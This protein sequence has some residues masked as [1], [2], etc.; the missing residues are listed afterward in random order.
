MLIISTHVKI[1][2]TLLHKLKWVFT[3]HGGV[4]SDYES[5]VKTAVASAL[6]HTSLV[7]L[8]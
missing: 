3:L 4:S 1:S 7:R 8:G 5:V 6:M 2:D